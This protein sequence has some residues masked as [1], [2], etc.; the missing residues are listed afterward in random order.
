MWAI[1]MDQHAVTVML[2]VA[3][4]RDVITT[5]DHQNAPAENAGGA[6]G[7]DATNRAG[8]A[9]QQVHIIQHEGP[10]SSL[11]RRLTNRGMATF[12]EKKGA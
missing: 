7:Q 6:L 12:L 2:I 8:S 3:V 1:T 9:D 11:M 10:S 4:T 5:I